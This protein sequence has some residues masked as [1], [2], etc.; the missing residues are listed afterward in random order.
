MFGCEQAVH[1]ALNAV[2]RKVGR[3]QP[4]SATLTIMAVLAIASSAGGRTERQAASST[5]TEPTLA[6]R[7]G[8][9]V[10]NVRDF[11]AKC[12]GMSDDHDAIAAVLTRLSSHAGGVALFPP[13]SKP[14][15]LAQNLSTPDNV[16]LRATPGT[17]V[18]KATL[19]NKSRPVLLAVGNNVVV[20]GLSFDGGG[21][22]HPTAENVIQGF[23]VSNVTFTRIAVRHTRGIGLMMSSNIGNS[24]VRDSV[25]ED[26]GNH[27][28]TSHLV[29]DRVEGVVFCCGDGNHGNVAE[30]NRF[31]DIGLD[32]LQ[33]SGQSGVTITGNRFDL[34]N[35]E[36]A[37]MS[38]PDYGAA[39]YL[40]N[41]S[42]AMISGNV[43]AGAQGNCIDAPTLVNAKI[44]H[45]I[46]TRCGSSGIGLFGSSIG[47]TR[48][49]VVSDNIINSNGQWKLSPHPGG[50]TLG[51]NIADVS[52]V[53]NTVTDTQAVKTQKYALYGTTDSTL[54]KLFI[55]Q[56]NRL[57]G[58]AISTFGGA[59][60]ASRFSGKLTPSC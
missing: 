52:L 59:I 28:K 21:K 49:I 17:V 34:E 53:G 31:S 2:R 45:N 51:G 26:L 29:R 12:D 40:P 9:E 27:W 58:N 20:D 46:L 8:P 24:A 48:G 30:N 42:Q 13:S 3:R 35:R 23:R 15:M 6:A 56:S 14:C 11:G 54:T 32:A 4:K 5:I 36:R 38:A 1:E 39:L 57:C 16:I 10:I 55:D 47:P 44:S 25:F 41:V 50:I 37:T 18:L 43:I 33:F 7:Y 22:D 19:D 60:D